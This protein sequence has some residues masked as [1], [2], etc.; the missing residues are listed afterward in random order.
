[1]T[2]LSEAYPAATVPA[3]VQQL[4]RTGTR[5][6]REELVA[7]GMD[8]LRPLHA[9]ML[10]PLIGGGRHASELADR[11]GV[12]RQAIAQVVATLEQGGYVERVDD[13]GDARAKLICLTSRGRGAVRAMRAG[14]QRIEDAWTAQLGAERMAALRSALADLLSGDGP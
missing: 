11:L 13:P 10:I 6:L 9:Q 1:M 14:A 2:T 3:L 4:A 5:R 8:G 12:T 7:Q